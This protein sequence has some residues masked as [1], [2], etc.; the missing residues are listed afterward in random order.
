MSRKYGQTL[1]LVTC[2]LL[3]VIASSYARAGRAKEASVP[4]VLTA[5][6]SQQL[7]DPQN[8][9]I[10][11]NLSLQ[12]EAKKFERR[13]GARF[14]GQNATSVITGTITTDGGGQPVQII[15]RQ[16]NRGERV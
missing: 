4:V 6:Q 5:S 2:V 7:G 12:P 13:I 10:T 3:A 9:A 15:R 16:T 1:I 14:T 8:S 11:R